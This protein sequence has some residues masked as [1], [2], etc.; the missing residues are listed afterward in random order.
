MSSK[1]Y[2]SA[3]FKALIIQGFLRFWHAKIV[4]K[5]TQLAADRSAMKRCFP[6]WNID[7]HFKGRKKAR[8]SAPAKVEKPEAAGESTLGFLLLHAL[9]TR[10]RDL[11]GRCHEAEQADFPAAL[12]P[13]VLG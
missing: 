2:A 12:K 9:Q 4:I 5:C 1:S 7:S 11:H 3:I 6:N 8:E 10:N 13:E